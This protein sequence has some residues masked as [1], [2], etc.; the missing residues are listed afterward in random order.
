MSSEAVYQHVIGA[1]TFIAPYL[2]PWYRYATLLLYVQREQYTRADLILWVG[3]NGMFYLDNYNN[4]I[5]HDA[6]IGKITHSIGG[7]VLSNNHYAPLKV[8]A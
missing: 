2:H 5:P 1:N 7:D 8:K 3:T 4:D 6:I